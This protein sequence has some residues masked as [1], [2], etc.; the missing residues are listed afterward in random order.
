MRRVA[1][2][3]VLLTA[4][5]T[6][7]T[8]VALCGYQIHRT[9]DRAL[10]VRLRTLAEAAA[11]PAADAAY[12]SDDRKAF[13]WETLRA[14]CPDVRGVLL[15][16]AVG[17]PVLAGG[18]ARL[19]EPVVAQTAGTDR[20]RRLTVAAPGPD[21]RVAVGVLPIRR[22]IGAFTGGT[23]YVAAAGTGRAVSLQEAWVY[24]ASLVG[25]GATGIFLGTVLLSR[26]VLKPIRTLSEQVESAVE[27]GGLPALPTD[28]DDEIGRLA[29]AFRQMQ[30]GLDEARERAARL[31]RTMDR[32]VSAETQ[33]IHRELR[34]VERRAWTDP[35]TGL[36]N[37]RLFDD[38]FGEIVEAQRRRGHDLAIVLL[39]VDHFKR[40]NDTLGHPA[41]DELLRF[42]GELLRQC[43]RGNDLAIR[44]GGD[45]F[46]L[47]LPSASAADAESVAERTIRLFAQ[48][49]KLMD[50]VPRPTMSA[51]VA[52]LWKARVSTAQELLEAADEALYAAKRS[53]KDRVG[54]CPGEP[55]ELR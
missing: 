1:L 14:A 46:L 32:R 40:V 38:K 44:M 16:D 21:G 53:G 19:I 18:E 3:A 26:Y 29:R 50:V 49:A 20:F 55:V 5:S 33:R 45:E 6:V 30:G 48:R 54:V 47:V 12:S 35:L 15:L 11:V 2:L 31:E 28:R 37:R 9:S 10:E 34:R 27:S 42:V 8:S 24:F 52:S 43:L 7:L 22:L 17:R 4:A 39:D 25:I 51:G 23:F 13:V 36:G 41:G